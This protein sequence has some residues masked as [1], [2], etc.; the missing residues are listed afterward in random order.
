MNYFENIRNLNRNLEH[1]GI[2]NTNLGN[3]TPCTM[4]L[5]ENDDNFRV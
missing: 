4:I 3:W 2:L 1:V 5:G